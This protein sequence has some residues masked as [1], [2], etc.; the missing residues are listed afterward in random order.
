MVVADGGAIARSRVQTAA[1]RKGRLSQ[2]NGPEP[3]G[4]SQCPRPIP[5]P[6]TDPSKALSE[7][8]R[9]FEVTL[10]IDLARHPC[11]PETQ[12]IRLA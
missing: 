10:E 9:L 8:K 3:R 7:P 11:A 5:P 2:R 6:D 12:L 1:L 4:G